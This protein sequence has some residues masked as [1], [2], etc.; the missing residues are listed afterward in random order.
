MEKIATPGVNFKV[1]TRKSNQT[2]SLNVHHTYQ[3]EYF[4]EI[5]H[6][7]KMT[8]CPQKQLL[9]TIIKKLS[10]PAILEPTKETKSQKKFNWSYNLNRD[11]FWSK[12]TTADKK[13]GFGVKKRSLGK[14]H[15][16]KF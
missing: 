9:I 1:V 11:L 16:T 14:E 12:N 4:F 6:I 15:R 2:I 10:A 7:Y 13:M 3:S 8:L 5:D